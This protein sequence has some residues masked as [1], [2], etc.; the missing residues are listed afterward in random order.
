M[1]ARVDVALVGPAPNRGREVPV[2]VEWSIGTRRKIRRPRWRK[3]YQAAAD[4]V[5]SHAELE[6]SL[7][8]GT[9]QP[10]PWGGPIGHAWV[11]F[12]DVVY[13]GTLGRFYD[14]AS[15]IETVHAVAEAR[16]S[17]REFAEK[18]SATGRL[19]PWHG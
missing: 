14:R 6:P 10:E 9:Y 11:E 16:Y 3:C 2:P 15:Y 13:D 19:G 1:H 18:I 8:H 5:L 7:V 12:P 17:V 4:Y